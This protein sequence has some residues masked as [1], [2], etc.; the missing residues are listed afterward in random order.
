MGSN[1]FTTSLRKYNFF[2][3]PVSFPSPAFFLS[4]G[5]PRAI[6][7]WKEEECINIPFSL[8]ASHSRSCFGSDTKDGKTE[9]GGQFIRFSSWGGSSFSPWKRRR[10]L[11]PHLLQP[12]I[13][14]ISLGG[15]ERLLVE[16]CMPRAGTT[17]NL[18]EFALAEE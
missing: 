17:T 6:P 2:M 13:S 18:N 16:G 14:V 9:L 8:L 7:A 1:H 3:P 12:W 15:A 10:F 5:A 4:P 11:L